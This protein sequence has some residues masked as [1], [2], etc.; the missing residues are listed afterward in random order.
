MVTGILDVVEHESCL[1][2]AVSLEACGD[3]PS[4]SLLVAEEVDFE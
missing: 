2:V 3:D 4:E 1:G